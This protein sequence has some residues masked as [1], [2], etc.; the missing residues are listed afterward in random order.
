MTDKSKA[1]LQAIEALVL[2]GVESP[3][4]QQVREMLGGGSYATIAPILKR[5]VDERDVARQAS[6]TMP[7][8]LRDRLELVVAQVWYAANESANQRLV[9]VQNLLDK[10]R[11]EWRVVRSEIERELER[12]SRKTL[13]LKSFIEEQNN[14]IF[15]LRRKNDQQSDEITN[16][17][18]ER[19]M[20]Q[21]ELTRVQASRLDF[22][23]HSSKHESFNST[24]K[25]ILP[26]KIK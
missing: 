13:E 3:T 2:K 20:L 15:M 11:K 18:V 9:A 23:L 6:V 8:S 7:D 10:E 19:V 12:L 5:W 16:Q 21:A 14:E 26:Q 1:V 4:N 22:E 24:P 17:K 25:I